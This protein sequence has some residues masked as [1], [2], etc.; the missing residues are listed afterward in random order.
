MDCDEPHLALN[1]K[2]QPIQWIEQPI[3]ALV[4]LGSLW[5][6]IG[7]K[8]QLQISTSSYFFMCK[9]LPM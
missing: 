5:P 3:G 4:A 7:S 2:M 1:E 6:Q 9:L 8:S